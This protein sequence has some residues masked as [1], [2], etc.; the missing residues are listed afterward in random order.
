MIVPL[1]WCCLAPAS[2]VA[3]SEPEKLIEAG[4][5]KQARA[6]VEPWIRAKP[7]DPLANFLLSQIRNA[8]GDRQSPLPLAE[9]A[10]QLDGGTAKYHR[11]LAEVLG[12]TAQYSGMLRQLFLARRFKKE[13]DTALALDPKDLQALG[14]LMEFYLLAPG[15]AGGDR[16]QA[17]AVADRIARIDAAAGFSAQARFGNAE[18]FLRKA[19]DA[20]PG[21]YR[22]RV[23]L[24]NYYLAASH[25]NDGLAEQQG[26]E[27][28]RIDPARMDAYAVLAG[29]DAARSDWTDMENVLATA[30]KE[31]PDDL[32]PYYRAA[33]A[34]LAQH[35]ELPRA[36]RLLRKYLA[37][38]PE[39]N[40]PTRADA[41]KL[42]VLVGQALSPGVT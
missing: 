24:A 2:A 17:R 35:R 19:V 11:Q 31:V 16:E 12:V 28:L 32:T 3:Q 9:K 21:N 39:G 15:I 5:W 29:I 7:N 33:Q 42:V 23:A 10:V 41:Q 36:E 14:D 18:A 34:I 8:F 4:H 20:Q 25:R 37:A 38:E 40:A 27:A 13:I 22:A 6:I 1:L 30:E 26:R